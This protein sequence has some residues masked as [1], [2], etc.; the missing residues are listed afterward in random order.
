MSY[1][2]FK[3]HRCII[4]SHKF[5]PQISGCLLIWMLWVAVAQAEPLDLSASIR[6]SLA[7]HPGVQAAGVDVDIAQAQLSEARAARF[8]PKFELVS[9]VGPSP[10]ARGD[11]L[12]GN[13]D[14]G[15]LNAFTRTEAMAIQPLYTFG[16]LDGA[17]QAATAGVRAYEAG[18]RRSRAD[19]ALQV[20][21]VY[22][23]LLLAN[24]LWELAQE[25]EGEFQ[26]ARDYVADKLE[27][28]EGDFTFSDL[29]RIDRFAYDVA[30]KVHEVQKGRA[31]AES[32][33]RLLLGLNAADSLVLAERLHLVDAEILPL[34][35]Y[36]DRRHRRPDMQQ[37]DAAVAARQALARVAKSDLY[38]QIFLAGQFKYA[39]APNRDNQKSPF[40]KDDFNFLQAGAVVGFQQSLAF[41]LNSARAKKARLEH[42]KLVHQADLAQKGSAIEIEKIY[43]EWIEARDN[44][45]AAEKA[46]TA[47]RRWFISV[48]DGFNMGLEKASDMIDA[49]K[50]YNIIRA[51]YFEAVFKYNRAWARLQRATGQSIAQ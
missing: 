42:Q 51:K 47:A 11:A 32:A 40:A 22:F 7:R 46:R 31:L 12:F 29:A 41:G 23:G 3:C 5:L 49:V 43:R 39:Y 36:V 37:L 48:R 16:K 35:D 45:A 24:E 13:T 18:L 38:P 1:V 20:A 25:A 6:L 19:V 4:F 17:Q 8:L 50:E 34:A 9:V 2:L 10:E 28:D 27:E 44:V 33:M 21:E 15:S 26:K 14:L 30:E